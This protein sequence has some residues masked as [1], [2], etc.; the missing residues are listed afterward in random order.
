MAVKPIPEGFHTVTPYLVVE[1][2][3]KL[4]QFLKQAFAA[5][6]IYVMKQSDGTIMHAQVQIGDSMIMLG[7]ACGEY[8]PRPGSVYLYVNNTDEL[9][10]KAI[11]AGA[12]SLREPAD[13]FYGD[14]SA[15]VKDFCGNQWWI[16]THIEDVS[17]EDIQKRAQALYAKNKSK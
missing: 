8:G 16:G 3:D 5:K 12:T 6:E 11:Q 14:R 13:Q 2:T 1:G 9:Y 10:K 4:I 15:G 17:D 7:E